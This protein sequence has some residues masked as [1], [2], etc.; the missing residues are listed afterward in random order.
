MKFLNTHTGKLFALLVGILL[1]INFIVVS[2]LLFYPSSDPH[3]WYNKSIKYDPESDTNPRSISVRYNVYSVEKISYNWDGRNKDGSYAGGKVNTTI[4]TRIKFLEPKDLS[5]R[6]VFDVYH[7][8]NQNRNIDAWQKQGATFN[9]K[10]SCL[11]Y[12]NIS[13]G[14]CKI[15]SKNFEIEP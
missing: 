6:G 2:F 3:V 14:T 15:Y 11:L 9:A 5:D 13:S 10:I 7:D 12:Q 4:S 8:G 1:L